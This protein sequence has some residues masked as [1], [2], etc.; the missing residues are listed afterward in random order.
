MGS[1]VR[2]T[3]LDQSI[4]MVKI[5]GKYKRT[6]ETK[7]E[8]FLNKLSV[9]W[10]KRKAALYSTPTMVITENNGH[11]KMVT[12]TTLASVVLEFELGKEFE[13][14]TADDRNCK[15]TVTKEGDNKLITSQKAQKSG[16]K[17]V[18]VIRTFTDA[19]IN[20]QMICGDVV[21]DQFYAR[22]D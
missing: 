9:S 6:S 4:K 3:S 18:K 11:W 21:S 8:D 16:Q 14:T 1:H 19:G 13:E 2:T 22:D 7:Y 17:D 15:T 5:T 20:V 12:A 10:P